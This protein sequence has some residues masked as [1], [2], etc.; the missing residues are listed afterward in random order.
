VI[1]LSQ[2]KKSKKNG[3]GFA[4][5]LIFMRGSWDEEVLEPLL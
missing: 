2:H 4:S 5:F 1:F 3:R